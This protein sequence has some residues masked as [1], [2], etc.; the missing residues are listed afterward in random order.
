MLTLTIVN[1]AGQWGCQSKSIALHFTALYRAS[2]LRLRTARRSVGVRLDDNEWGPRSAS[3]AYSPVLHV[4]ML[5]MQAT[6]QQPL[7]DDKSLPVLVSR[8]KCPAIR[9]SPDPQPGGGRCARLMKPVQRMS[10]SSRSV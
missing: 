9:D 2:L 8:W 5:R 4:A 6:T 1:T 7:Q 3:G 10:N